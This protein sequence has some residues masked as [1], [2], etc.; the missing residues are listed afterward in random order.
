MTMKLKRKSD[1]E[2]AND[3]EQ[4]ALD[5][6]HIQSMGLGE[7]GFLR[8]S[9]FR[10]LASCLGLSMSELAPV[11]GKS[12]HT[13][14][15]WSTT[16][17]TIAP[18]REILNQMSDLVLAQAHASLAIGRSVEAATPLSEMEF[19]AAILAEYN[20]RL[21]EE[22]VTAKVRLPGRVGY[23]GV[24]TVTLPKDLRFALAAQ[25]VAKA[26]WTEYQRSLQ[27]TGPSPLLDR[28]DRKRLVDWLVGGLNFPR[29]K[30]ADMTGR[31]LPTV[32]SWMGKWP[33]SPPESVVVDLL[34][35][36]LAWAVEYLL[37]ADKPIMERTVPAVPE[38]WTF[39]K[40]EDM[41]DTAGIRISLK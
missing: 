17:H 35:L 18:S 16:W 1:A 25:D 9:E 41:A 13:L 8:K 27:E 3:A 10:R 12:K 21:L 6:E 37:E 11:L 24:I 26:A 38:H 40:S 36:H 14:A 39:R 29:Q 22:G 23:L 15:S 20:L 31:A 4:A 34:R 5:A 30:L 2:R 28:D 19:R 7:D 32:N 33:V